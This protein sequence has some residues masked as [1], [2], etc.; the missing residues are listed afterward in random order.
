MTTPDERL[1]IDQQFAQKMIRRVDTNLD[2]DIFI[3]TVDKAKLCLKD[4]LQK[5]EDQKAWITPA[6]ILITLLLVFT[7]C[8]FHDFL[9]LT[10]DFWHAFYVIVA[11]IMGIWI[12]RSLIRIKKCPTVDDVISELRADSEK[13]T[14]NP[15]RILQIISAKYGKNNK[16]NDVTKLLQSKI[17]DGSISLKVTNDTMGGDPIKGTHKELIVDYLYEGRADKRHVSENDYLILP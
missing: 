15:F 3:T 17:T 16:F 1:V 10:K 11:V 13:L 2:T 7:T 5:M 4:A 8:S 12:V 14:K 6:G 9:Y